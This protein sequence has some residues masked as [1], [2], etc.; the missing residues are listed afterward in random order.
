MKDAAR[1]DSARMNAE[2]VTAAA[3]ADVSLNRIQA[4]PRER[5]YSC[6]DSWWERS[7]VGRR[8]AHRNN[9]EESNKGNT[10]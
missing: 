9:P 10:S 8:D 7:R 6:L 2:S 3:K 1:A 4:R 5:R